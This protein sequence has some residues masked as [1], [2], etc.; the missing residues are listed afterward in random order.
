MN[1]ISYLNFKYLIIL[2]TENGPAYD[3]SHPAQF[4]KI[5]GSKST[6]IT[7]RKKG[8]NGVTRNSEEID[9]ENEYQGIETS[10]KDNYQANTVAKEETETTRGKHFVPP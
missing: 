2:G 6:N 7:P 3:S 8:P 9:E 4:S 10:T 5:P 1:F